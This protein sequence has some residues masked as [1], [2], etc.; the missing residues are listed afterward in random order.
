MTWASVLNVKK[1]QFLKVR[2]TMYSLLQ[3][4]KTTIIL[5]PFEWTVCWGAIC[6]FTGS[7]LE[8]LVGWFSPIKEEN[9]N[10]NNN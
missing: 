9:E 8:H 7:Y 10:E 1:G 6:F 4:L 3:E 2:K 5:N